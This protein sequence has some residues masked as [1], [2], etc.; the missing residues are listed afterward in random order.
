MRLAGNPVRQAALVL[1]LFGADGLPAA[2]S[3]GRERGPPDNWSR[4]KRMF[5]RW[6]P[7]NAPGLPR[8]RGTFQTRGTQAF[9]LDYFRPVQSP[10]S[11]GGKKS[12]SCSARG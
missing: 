10:N 11:D 5:L 7:A 3:S 4:S 2:S 6:A 9:A 8:L 1:L 12:A